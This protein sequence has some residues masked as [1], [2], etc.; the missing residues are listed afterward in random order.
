ME[1]LKNNPTISPLDEAYQK[2]KDELRSKV[3]GVKTDK[4]LIEGIMKGNISEEKIN[5]L[6]K[7][8]I[9]D[10]DFK[11]YYYYSREFLLDIKLKDKYGE[12]IVGKHENA[13]LTLQVLADGRIVSGGWDGNIYRWTPKTNGKGYDKKLVREYKNSVNTLQVLADAKIV[14][15]TGKKIIIL[16]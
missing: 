7:Q 15:N 12:K 16:E 8:T 11:S 9:S 4:E 13:I 14:F 2:Y 6:K 3:I 5:E 10:K 1:S